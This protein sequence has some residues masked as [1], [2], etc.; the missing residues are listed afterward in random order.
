ME[1]YSESSLKLFA[2]T[3]Y[4]FKIGSNYDIDGTAG[5]IKIGEYIHLFL[6]IIYDKN[7]S[8]NSKIISCRYSAIGSTM[9]I[10]SAE[11]LCALIHNLSITD[12]LNKCNPDDKFGLYSLDVVRGKEHSFNFVLQAFYNAIQNISNIDINN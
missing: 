6:N 4:V 1:F 2:D 5:D 11:Y 8:L 10:I 9:L 3:K 7:N 12:A